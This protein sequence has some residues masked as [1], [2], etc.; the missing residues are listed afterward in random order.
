MSLQEVQSNLKL[1]PLLECYKY[2]GITDFRSTAVC[3]PQSMNPNETYVLP[4][5]HQ[6]DGV[7][8]SFHLPE[9]SNR[10]Y[11]SKALLLTPF[12]PSSSESFLAV[13][14]TRATFG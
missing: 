12:S 4:L 8:H 5:L 7:Y 14:L 10:E 11:Q 1:I 2:F 6:S 13:L 3:A 9:F